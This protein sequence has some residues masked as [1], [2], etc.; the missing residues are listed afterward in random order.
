[1]Q[2]T[3]DDFF[4][5]E[6]E[7]V[8]MIPTYAAAGLPKQLTERGIELLRNQVGGCLLIKTQETGLPTL[9]PKIE[10][11]DEEYSGLPF[12][13]IPKMS[14]LMNLDSTLINEETGIHLA[15]SM[16]IIQ[17]FLT[18][19]FS[20]YDVF[21]LG[22][23][24]KTTAH[25]NFQI[26]DKTFPVDALVEVD[27]YFESNDRIVVLEAKQ[28]ATKTRRLDFSIHQLALPLLLVRSQTEKTCSGLLLDWRI[29]KRA[30]NPAV[31]F[32]LYHYEIQGDATSINPFNYSL[33]KSKS[34]FIK[35]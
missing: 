10:E 17:S 16:G 6:C 7:P 32:K 28:S 24:L 13:S 15:W 4:A 18:D 3:S 21:T 29:E 31:N 35:I 9:Y 8:R 12:H 5:V 25:G 11:P 19:C 34:Y 20:P 26:K 23:R 2:L 1:L 27:G 14:F 30:R 22:G 33:T